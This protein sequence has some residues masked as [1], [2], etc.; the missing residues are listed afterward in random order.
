MSEF[1]PGATTPSATLTGLNGPPA[2]AFDASGNLYVANYGRHHGERVRSG[3]H[4]A[5]R[6]PH[7]AGLSRRPWPSTPAATS[8]WPT[9]TDSDTVSKF[10]PG[11][12]TPTATLTGLDYPVALAFDPSGNLYVANWSATTVS[13]FA[14]GATTPTATLTGLNDPHALAVDSSGNLY[15]AN[16]APGTVS[17]FTPGGHHARCHPHRAEQSP[18]PGLRRQR[19][20]LCGQR[21]DAGTVSEFASGGHHAHRHPQRAGRSRSPWPSTPAATSTWPTARAR[22]GERVRSCERHP[23]AGGVVIRSS[24]PTRPMSIGGTNNAVA[25]INL[26]NAELAQIYTTATGTVTF[27]DSSPDRQHH[28]HHR[29]ARHHRRAHRPWSSS[30][31]PA[32]ARS[33]STTPAAAPAER[34]RRHGHPDPGHRRHREPSTLPACRWPTQGFNATGLTLS[35]PQFAPTLGTQLTVINNTATPAASHPITGTFANLPQGGT[36]SAT[37]GGT[38]YWFQANY[39]GGDGNDLVLTAIATPTTTTLSTSQASVTYGTPVTFTAT[40]SAQTGS[41]APTA[42]SVEFFDSTTGR[43]LG[44]G[45]L[46]GSTGTTAFGP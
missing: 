2:L 4:H 15:V 14:P 29:H 11:A 37:Y 22:H 32:Q 34:Q 35:H 9:W 6:H 24:L 27:G 19:Q 28:L 8:T 41:T 42:G 20:P 10:A 16:T 1:A 21:R 36:I 7:R 39:A 25:G 31:P 43:D 23:T 13:E 45:S 30:P 46:A 5:H 12:T 38:T 33:S 17:E 3:G 26:T 44:D 40:V 18:G